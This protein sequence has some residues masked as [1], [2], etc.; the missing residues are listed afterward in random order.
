MKLFQCVLSAGTLLAIIPH[1]LSF[2]AGHAEDLVARDVD[3][4]DE[5]LAARESD[6]FDARDN[7]IYEARTSPLDDD[8]E[9]RDILD[10]LDSRDLAALELREILED[11]EV[12]DPLIIGVF[13]ALVSKIKDGIAKRKAKRAAKKAA[14]AAAAARGQK[15]SFEDGWGL[16]QRGYE[17][18]D[19][20]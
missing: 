19:W 4:F 17:W 5:I 18:D 9:I 16:E 20:Y 6:F 2:E 10:Q 12:R 15:R 11:L 13:K 7:E 14:Q 3:L 1:V 8:L